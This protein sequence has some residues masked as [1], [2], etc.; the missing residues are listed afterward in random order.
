MDKQ[1]IEAFSDGVFAVAITLLVL[2]FKVTGLSA[3]EL[4]SQ[5]LGQWPHLLAYILSFVIVGV[6]WVA[7]HTLFHF[8]ART[9]RALL[10][11]NNFFLMTVAFLPFPAGLL[12]EYP[13]SQ[14]SIV[15][16]G[17][18]L[19][20]ANTSSTLTWIY[21][22]R[23]ALLYPGTPTGFRR[24]A[25]QLT[26]APVIVYGIAVAISFVNLVIPRLLFA[27]VPVFF[28]VP[29]RLVEGRVAETLK[30]VSE[31]NP[32]RSHVSSE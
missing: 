18:T 22:S 4:R 19:I 12:G 24:F 26:F 14:I 27:A 6:Y 2:N 25:A 9:S 17:S 7:H 10:W 11:L 8:V 31:H 23:A 5:V 21:A 29:H 3:S 28:I 30:T 1:R 32:A 16:Y 15:L 13:S 20:A